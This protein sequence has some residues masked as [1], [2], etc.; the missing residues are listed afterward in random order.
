M[1]INN[2][3]LNI[4]K[5][6]KKHRK[7]VKVLNKS[8]S[9]KNTQIFDDNCNI[10]K[11]LNLINTKY[12]A[13]TYNDVNVL[14]FNNINNGT[15]I[16][17]N[18]N[19]ITSK[20][21][22]APPLKEYQNKKNKIGKRNVKNNLEEF[23]RYNI[24]QLN[25]YNNENNFMNHNNNKN[26][27]SCANIS[28]LKNNNSYININRKAPRNNNKRINKKNNIKNNNLNFNMDFENSNFFM[29]DNNRINIP[30]YTNNKGNTIDIIESINN[31][32]ITAINN[33]RLYKNNDKNKNIQKRG[34]NMINPFL[35]NRR[36]IK[37]INNEKT[38]KNDVNINKYDGH[39]LLNN[40]SN[41]NDKYS[42]IYHTPKK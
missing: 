21:N 17:A 32:R 33:H 38:N 19:N 1:I 9:T 22:F 25:N 2:N 13:N 41:Q 26:S 42:T 11:N 18:Y 37:H 29:G 20:Y 15:N 40:I 8:Y 39:N 28:K 16:N 34:A 31:N 10:N 27:I 23:G 12:N 30:R 36:N 3:F 35:A 24:R 6:N 5:G 14:T 4:N 7:R